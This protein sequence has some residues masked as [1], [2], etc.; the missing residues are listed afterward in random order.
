MPTPETQSVAIGDWPTWGAFLLAGISLAWQFVNE[1]RTSR[2]ERVTYYVSRIEAIEAHIAEIRSLAMAYWLQPEEGS[3]RDSL[4]LIHHI[5]E[6]SVSASRYQTFLW[7]GVGT[8][9]LRLKIETTGSNFQQADRK[10][11]K[12]DDPFVKRFMSTASDLGRR[13]KDRRD[14]IERR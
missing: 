3:A 1:W 9:V 14:E 12:S 10:Q 7:H 8:D 4:M 2:K 5:R 6:L 11:L 13:L